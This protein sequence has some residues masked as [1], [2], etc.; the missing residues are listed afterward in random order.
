VTL[1]YRDHI[2]CKCSKIISPLVSL[3]FLLCADPNT[4]DLLQGEHPD[5]LT[6]KVDGIEK[7]AFGIQSSNITDKQQKRIKVTIEVQ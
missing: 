3:G 6:G 5:I 1:K 7:A 2:G 4:T